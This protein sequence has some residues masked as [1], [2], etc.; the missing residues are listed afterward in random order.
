[1]TRANITNHSRLIHVALEQNLKNI[2][3]GLLQSAERLWT[4]TEAQSEHFYFL[5]PSPK[6]P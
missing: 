1:M 4:I 3:Y 2:A 6:T 5:L